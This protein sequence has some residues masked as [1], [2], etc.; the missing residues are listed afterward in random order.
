MKHRTDFWEKIK[1]NWPL[2]TRERFRRM[3]ADRDALLKEHKKMSDY[4][5]VLNE[6]AQKALEHIEK[7]TGDLS[8]I[9]RE[10]K[11]IGF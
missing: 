10:L 5:L 7:T 3:K 4:V 11:R 9:A 8:M 1:E 6:R 2:V